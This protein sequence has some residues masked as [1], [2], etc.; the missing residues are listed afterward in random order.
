MMDLEEQG[1]NVNRVRPKL[2][3]VGKVALCGVNLG[4]T[5]ARVW[6]LKNR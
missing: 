4:L 6:S 5:L 3:T 1:G 2:T